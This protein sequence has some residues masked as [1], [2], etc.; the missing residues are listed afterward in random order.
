MAKVA[1]HYTLAEAVNFIT[2]NPKSHPKLSTL[3]SLIGGGL[4]VFFMRPTV[5]TIFVC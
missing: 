5:K 3:V 2:K 1:L 4:E